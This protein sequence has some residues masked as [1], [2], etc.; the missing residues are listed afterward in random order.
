MK[1]KIVV[2][3]RDRKS[4]W[5][6]RIEYEGDAFS[7]LASYKKFLEGR[8]LT[9]VSI[10]RYPRVAIEH[11]WQKSCLVTIERKGKLFD[12]YK[13]VNCG[14]TGKRFGLDAEIAIDKKSFR[15]CKHK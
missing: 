14:A 7:R 10:D 6:E 3:I 5:R 2:L 11:S 1:K 8:G 12:T 9:L 13:C 4:M 15:N